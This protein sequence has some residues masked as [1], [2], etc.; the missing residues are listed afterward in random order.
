MEEEDLG[1]LAAYMSADNDGLQ[2]ERFA[3]TS[4]LKIIELADAARTRAK[5]LRSFDPR[6]ADEHETLFDRLQLAAAALLEEAKDDNR[7]GDTLR[8][9]LESEVGQKALNLAVTMRAKTLFT[10]PVVQR[11]LEQ[12]WR[13]EI[14]RR[15]VERGRL[16]EYGVG[17]ILALLLVVEIVFLVPIIALVAL[18]R[19]MLFEGPFKL[20]EGGDETGKRREW[21][22]FI[23]ID[24][25]IVKFYLETASDIALVL[26]LTAVPTDALGEY[27]MAPILLVWIV[28]AFYWESKQFMDSCNDF[29][30]NIAEGLASSCRTRSILW[31]PCR[32][33]SRSR[34]SSPPSPNTTATP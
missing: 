14:F 32:W 27:P 19:Y 12:K 24:A 10:Q 15:F 18:E 21:A 23:L 7:E 9:L 20:F 13:S 1:R 25:P 4:V 34:P 26:V 6:D 8:E 22:P 29:G 33:A 31:T 11:Y 3:G 2:G 17:C 28:A 5:Q 30:V 16:W